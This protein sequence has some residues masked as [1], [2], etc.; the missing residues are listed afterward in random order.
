MQ[1]HAPPYRL[2]LV[3]RGVH[4]GTFGLQVPSEDFTI[5]FCALLDGLAMIQLNQRP[6]A[7][8]RTRAGQRTGGSTA[9]GS[10]W[11]CWWLASRGVA[12]TSL[13]RSSSIDSDSRP[14][15]ASTVSSAVSQCS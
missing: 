11:A 12:S 13:V 2:V 6:L 14:L 4:E 1:R 9:T 5:C 7:W 8:D 10:R 15:P 3:Q